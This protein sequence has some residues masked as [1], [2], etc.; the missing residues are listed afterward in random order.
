MR[1][2][3]LIVMIALLPLR[4]WAGIVMA[5]EMASGAISR[6]HHQS[7]SAIDSGAS[8]TRIHWDKA[9]FQGQKTTFETV[10]IAFEPKHSANP[11]MAAIP[12]CPGHVKADASDQ[13]Q[14]DAS[15]S[16]HCESCSA[17]QACHSVAMSSTAPVLPAA[18]APRALPRPA[19][20]HFAS[21]TS[22]LSQKPPIS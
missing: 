4:G 11:A 22:A 1:V 19:D 17:C 20:A 2:L 6:A 3:L 9:N 10:E 14:T 12:D 16:G 7:T 15:G 13:A 18:F 5:T 8:D 21:A